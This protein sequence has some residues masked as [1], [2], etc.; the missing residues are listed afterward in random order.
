MPTA[1]NQLQTKLADARAY[2]AKL[3]EQALKEGHSRGDVADA[4][5]IA[6]RRPDDS[7]FKFAW[8]CRS[9]IG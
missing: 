6:V 8:R 7:P 9:S 3:I 4:A 2:R 5:R 1:V